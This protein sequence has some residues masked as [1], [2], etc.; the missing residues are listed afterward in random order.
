MKSFDHL[1]PQ[2]IHYPYMQSMMDNDFIG[3]Y[4]LRLDGSKQEFLALASVHDGEWEH[5]SVS[6]EFRCPR[7]DEMRQVKELFFEDDE[8]VMQLHPPKKDYVN[9]HPFCLHLWRPVSAEIPMP[10][11]DMV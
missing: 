4:L 7:W 6:T 1:E 3:A 2:R 10:N 8:T 11:I 9:S 5:V